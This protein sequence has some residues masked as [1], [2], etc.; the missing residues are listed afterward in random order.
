M[1]GI[2]AEKILSK[3]YDILVRIEKH[4]LKKEPKKVKPIGRIG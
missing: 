2:V 4:L 3:I 1:N